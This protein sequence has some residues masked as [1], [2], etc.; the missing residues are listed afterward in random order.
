MKFKNAE[1]GGSIGKCLVEK[2]YKSA[3]NRTNVTQLNVWSHTR[4]SRIHEQGER[5]SNNYVSSV[6]M[7]DSKSRLCSPGVF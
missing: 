7:S 4:S 1:T 6:S 3:E 5:R 2:V